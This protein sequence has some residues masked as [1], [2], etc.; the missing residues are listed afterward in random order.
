MWYIKVKWNRVGNLAI[1]H[2]SC[3]HV[4]DDNLVGS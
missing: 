1:E 2:D 4:S 3:V